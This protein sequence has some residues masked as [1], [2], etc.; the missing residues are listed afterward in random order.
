MSCRCGERTG[1]GISLGGCIR[2][3][4]EL[5]EGFSGEFRAS[6]GLPFVVFALLE[7]AEEVDP[8]DR[9]LETLAD[10]GNGKP[11][12]IRGGNASIAVPRVKFLQERSDPGRE[13]AHRGGIVPAFVQDPDGGEVLDVYLCLLVSIG[14]HC[15]GLGLYH[16]GSILCGLKHTKGGSEGEVTN[17]IEREVVVP[18]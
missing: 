10:G 12:Q 3:S 18:W 4:D 13:N 11:G 17:D 16:G 14:G 7:F 9:G 2:A 8:I 15:V 1:R 6:H 5:S